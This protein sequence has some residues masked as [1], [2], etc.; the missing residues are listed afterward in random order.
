MR[1]GVPKVQFWG[2]CCLV[3]IYISTI[4]LNPV[5]NQIV[6]CTLTIL[7][8]IVFLE[9]FDSNNIE[10]EINYELEKVNLWLKAYKLSLNEKTSKCMFFHKRK[11]L[12]HS[13]LSINDVIIENVPKCNYLGIMIDEHLSWNCHIELIGLKV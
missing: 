10:R 7:L 4:C 2:L 6:L 9:N 3:Y 8:C 1:I 12:P 11:T 5:Q 13:N